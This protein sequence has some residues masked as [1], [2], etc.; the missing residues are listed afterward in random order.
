MEVERR[1]VLKRGRDEGE[2]ENGVERK[3]KVSNLE[4]AV[5]VT[6]HRREP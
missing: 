3:A 2:A 5:A 4:S 1:G 6:S